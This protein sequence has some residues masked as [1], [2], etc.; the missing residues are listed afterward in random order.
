MDP[1]TVAAIQSGASNLSGT[2]LG[3]ASQKSTNKA[4]LK[5]AEYQYSKA[6]E[7]WNR[8]N[9]YNLPKNQIQ[10]LTD[11]GLN[12][13]LVYGNGTVQGLISAPAPQ[14]HAPTLQAYTNFGSLGA[15][16]AVTTYMQLKQA[17]ANVNKTNAEAERVIKEL[18][19]IDLDINLKRLDIARRGILNSI[20][21]KERDHWEQTYE[22]MLDEMQSRID[23]NRSEVPFNLSRE[24]N[25]NADTEL[26][27][28]KTKTEEEKPGLI[29]AQRI[30]EEGK[31]ALMKSQMAQNYANVKKTLSD[32]IRNEHLNDLTD[33]QLNLATGELILQSAK[34]NGMLQENEIRHILLKYGIDLREHG[35]IG[36]SQKTTYLL[37]RAIWESEEKDDSVV[38]QELEK[39]K[40]SKSFY[41]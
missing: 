39:N 18:P 38:K 17:D 8:Q 6:L 23:R 14:Y 22:M 32:I 13:N 10:R 33:A 9:E 2:L 40:P 34:H 27:K 41:K 1:I 3:Y 7:M 20:D 28:A 29:R 4:N 35:T 30:T 25:Y 11:A 36:L 19:L 5:L 26:K 24:N 37:N 15:E 21:E 31:P 16:Q 12:P